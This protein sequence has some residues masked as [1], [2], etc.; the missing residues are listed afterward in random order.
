[1]K[2]TFRLSY[3]K[4]NKKE[5]EEL[6]NDY[7]FFKYYLKSLMSDWGDCY[8]MYWGMEPKERL[9]HKKIII[10]HLNKQEFKRFCKLYKIINSFCHSNE[11]D[12]FHLMDDIFIFGYGVL[13]EYKEFLIE[14]FDKL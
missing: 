1:M 14:K 10:Q 2:K 12:R 8:K 3:S 13:A 5:A 11:I 7:D 6:L 4:K 9:K